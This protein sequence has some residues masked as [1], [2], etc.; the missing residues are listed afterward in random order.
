M[1]ESG[2]CKGGKLK[3][4][5]HRSFLE[6]LGSRQEGPAMREEF[7]THFIFFSGS[8]DRPEHPGERGQLVARIQA[9][10]IRKNPDPR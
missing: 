3:H 10:G 2:T 6:G 1:T 5:Y 4:D 9:A 7:L 8:A